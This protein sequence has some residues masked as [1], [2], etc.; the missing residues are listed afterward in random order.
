MRYPILTLLLIVLTSCDGAAQTEE[1]N[2]LREQVKT[3][4][5]EAS[6]AKQAQQRLQQL[7]GYMQ[8]MQARVSTTAGDIVIKFYPDLAPIHVLA[9]MSRAE[10]GFYNDTYFHRVIPGF[11]IQGGDPNT[12]NTNPMDD[13]LGGPMGAIPHEFSPT[14]HKRGIVSMARVSEK[15][16]GAGSQFF[17]MH[18]DY[19][20]LDNEY[21]VFG[22]VVSGM[23]VVDQ[24]ATAETNKTD[25][26]LQDRPL[27]PV[28]I[29]SIE[30]FKAAN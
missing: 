19:P 20:S 14:P 29:T 12:K 4:E 13:G 22:E 6:A 5:T 25:P 2:R 3:L 10:S 18:A 30:I 17:I 11:M 26:R 16:M 8:G 7:S 1:L 15:S 24:I 28:K 23:E 21:T 9:F 27:N